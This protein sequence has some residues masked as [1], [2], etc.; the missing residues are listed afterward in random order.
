MVAMAGTNKSVAELRGGSRA[1]RLAFRCLAYFLRRRPNFM[2]I[3]LIE[4]V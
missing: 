3:R 4:A 1:A 2:A